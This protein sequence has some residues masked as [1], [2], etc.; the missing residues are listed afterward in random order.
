[1]MIEK[2][3]NRSGQVWLNVASST[4]VLEDFA[5][6][7]NSLFLRMLPVFALLRPI[8]S[9]GHA[10]RMEEYR[11]AA[12][13]CLLLRHDCRR[14]L[15]LPASSVDHLLCSHFLEHVSASEVPGILRD[16]HRVL[17]PGA[18]AHIIVPDV[19]ILVDD[20]VR[21]RG[22]PAAGDDFIRSLLLR[23]EDPGSLRFRFL[24][25]LGGLGLQHLWMYDRESMTAR[26]LAAGFELDGLEGT[27]SSGYRRDD[28]VSLHLMARK[29]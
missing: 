10:A 12:E 24:D 27:P 13:R 20:Y 7:D 8:L 26:L 17:K 3:R 1:M 2:L 19:S 25:F 16:F 22:A 15:P 29:G 28:G 23:R 18:R 5:N 9:P 11:R 4:E 14:P 6:L 21:H